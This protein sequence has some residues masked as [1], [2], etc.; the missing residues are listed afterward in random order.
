MSNLNCIEIFVKD[1][2]LEVVIGTL[3][4]HIPYGWEE[5]SLLT[6]E[7][8]FRI[9]CESHEV[10]DTICSE[11]QSISPSIDLK[12][13][14]V[15][16]QDWSIAWRDFFTPVTAGQF[17]ILPPWLLETT[18]KN[19]QHIVVIEPKCAFGT[20]HHATTVLCLEAISLC[21]EKGYIQPGMRFFDLGTG[22]GILGIACSLVGLS[23]IGADI[24]PIATSNALEN[25]QLNK[26]E[27]QMTVVEA[28]VEIAA[29][30]HFDLVIAN[31]LAEPLKCLSSE[32]M[33]LL[34]PRGS[35]ILSGL[36][37][38]QENEVEAAYSKLGKAQRFVLGEWVTL[39]WNT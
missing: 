10:I 30:E 26:I 29:G 34:T 2:E 21:L 36:L 3:F 14:K 37:D 28:G 33:K 4:Q 8:L 38:Y 20:G 39:I 13:K 7:T 32:L 16:V 25:I 18:S 22:T 27:E 17:L 15:P 1:T 23:G 11:L 5:E 19:N 9:H 24:D 12:I 31:I 6:G 35:L